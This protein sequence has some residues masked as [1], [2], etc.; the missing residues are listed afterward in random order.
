MQSDSA[1][2]RECR[3]RKKGYALVGRGACEIQKDFA[4]A[5]HAFVTLL[6]VNLKGRGEKKVKV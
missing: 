4:R 2:L 3:E 6:F 1:S 5:F